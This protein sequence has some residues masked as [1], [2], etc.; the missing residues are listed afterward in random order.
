MGQD[1]DCCSSGSYFLCLPKKR[2]RGIG[3]AIVRDLEKSPSDVEWAIKHWTKETEKELKKK[4]S[5][6]LAAW[7]ETVGNCLQFRG[8]I[9][10]AN[11]EPGV[12]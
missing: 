11:Q 3:A 4:D 5:D 6:M 7:L 2:N 1:R 8:L 9:R 12:E 10:I